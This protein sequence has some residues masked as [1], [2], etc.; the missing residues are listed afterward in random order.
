MRG[1]RVKRAV[2]SLLDKLRGNVVRVWRTMHTIA[3]H[4]VAIRSD[5]HDRFVGV[6]SENERR[7]N[8]V[9]FD[10]Q[11]FVQVYQDSRFGKENVLAVMA[12]WF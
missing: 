2:L 9:H 4:R 5:E 8:D 10:D 11:A 7:E 3:A 1:A 6:A 12:R